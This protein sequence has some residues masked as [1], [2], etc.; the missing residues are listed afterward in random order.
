MMSS[1]GSG[2]PQA[3]ARRPRRD[4]G[5]RRDGNPPRRSRPGHEVLSVPFRTGQDL[6]RSHP[7]G[8]R[9]GHVR[10]VRPASRGREGGLPA[11]R[12]R[13]RGHRKPR[14]GD[15]PGPS[16]YSAKKIGGSPAYKLARARKEFTLEPARVVVRS[17]ALRS[18]A[19]PFV[20]FKAVCSSGTYIR[21]LA[22]DLGLR[23]GCGAHLHSLR[24]TSVGPYTIGDAVSLAGIEEAL[25]GGRL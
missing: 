17:F 16:P 2:P 3:Q 8:F 10:R 7:A 23:I 18:Y 5:P 20:E 9:H 4:P 22:H 1:S 12:S 14:G 15:P 24:R 19:P 21:S 13:N 6:R 11:P 25:A